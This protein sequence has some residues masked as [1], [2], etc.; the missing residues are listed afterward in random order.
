MKYDLIIKGGRVI[1]PS[2]ALDDVRDV[3]LADG[4]VA[5]VEPALADADADEVLD[6]RL[7]SS[8]LPA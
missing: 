2:Q 6:A 3:G 1:D 5:A 8:S 4:T 7:G